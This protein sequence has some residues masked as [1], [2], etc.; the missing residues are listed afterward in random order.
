MAHMSSAG[1]P[2][3]TLNLELAYIFRSRRDAPL[4]DL[5]ES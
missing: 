2:D 5:L 1:Q 4:R 3:R